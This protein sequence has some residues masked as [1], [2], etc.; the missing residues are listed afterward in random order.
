MPNSELFRLEKFSFTYPGASTPCLHAIDLVIRP[1][2][3]VLL[4]G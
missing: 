4:S 2:D 3:F 1:G